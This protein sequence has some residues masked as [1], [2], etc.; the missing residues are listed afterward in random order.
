M[1]LKLQRA[2]ETPRERVRC[3]GR[4]PGPLSRYLLCRSDLL[5][6]ILHF[7]RSAPDD[8]SAGGL[9]PALRNPG[10]KTYRYHRN[11]EN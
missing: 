5:P 11:G 6:V 8:S 2:E 1:V 9:S 10:H 7:K 4:F 3:R